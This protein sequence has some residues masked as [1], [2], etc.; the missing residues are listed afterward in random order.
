MKNKVFTEIAVK[1]DPY[2]RDW[3]TGMIYTGSPV[4]LAGS[5]NRLQSENA[6]TIPC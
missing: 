5:T 2:W 4:C 6:S 3:C 1:V